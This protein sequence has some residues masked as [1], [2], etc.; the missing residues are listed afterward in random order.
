MLMLVIVKVYDGLVGRKVS[1]V[2]TGPTD[3]AYPV[4]N[5]RITV[6]FTRGHPTERFGRA[7]AM[8]LTIATGD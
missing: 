4:G 5:E 1:T 3:S 8:M 7:I 6:R 2:V